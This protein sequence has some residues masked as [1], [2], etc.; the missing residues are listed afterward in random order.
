MPIDIRKNFVPFVNFVVVKLS[1]ILRSNRVG[2]DEIRA[3]RSEQE[4][5]DHEINSQQ[6]HQLN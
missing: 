2:A 6:S 1:R 5:P 3:E 4:V